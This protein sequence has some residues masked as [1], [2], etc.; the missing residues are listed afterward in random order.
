MP[1]VTP[2]SPACFLRV[3]ER[4]TNAPIAGARVEG[5]GSWKT[6]ADGQAE[7]AFS[8]ASPA[9]L[10]IRAEGFGSV[11]ARPL[12]GHATRSTAQ[13][14]Y[15]SKPST[16]RVRVVDLHGN[17]IPAV[18]VM[19][20]AGLDNLV[21]PAPSEV[22]AMWGEEIQWGGH[23]D[24]TGFCEFSDLPSEVRITARLE[25][26]ARLCHFDSVVLRPGEHVEREWRLGTGTTV[27]GLL[28]DQS[29][30]PVA[31]ELLFLQPGTE[32]GAEALPHAGFDNTLLVGTDESGRFT[33]PDLADG[34]WRLGKEATNLTAIHHS[35]KVGGPP[36]ILR[37]E[38]T[39]TDREVVVRFDREVYIEGQVLD[40]QGVGVGA[41]W[42]EARWIDRPELSTIVGF[43]DA[44]GS[45]SV[46]PVQR[47]QY[48]LVAGELGSGSAW[49]SHFAP[50]QPR[51]V[52]AGDQHVEVRLNPGE[53]LAGRVVDGKTGVTLTGETQFEVWSVREQV[54]WGR[55]D[56]ESFQL[57][58]LGP[59]EY[60]VVVRA[61]GGLIGVISA[62]EVRASGN[63]ADVRVPVWPGASLYVRYEG[64]GE[65]ATCSVEDESGS[66]ATWK[67]ERG[68]ASTRLVVPGRLRVLARTGGTAEPTG[69]WLDLEP[70]ES[71]QVVLRDTR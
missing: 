50:S 37:L 69:E 56:V 59:G 33:I 36:F 58:G 26:V 40:P 71:R 68:E 25:C 2:S 24:Q 32:S 51:T 1:S 34:T 48:V 3:L 64:P 16:L 30:Q 52:Q 66:V 6:D 67:L 54:A 13:T 38:A 31:G 44:G 7:I 10:T 61:Q 70:G 46:G 28:L 43:S 29:D 4:E 49:K 39:E 11:R 35:P 17:P 27:C 57:W 19:L 20:S 55:Q 45:F 53:S 18:A 5:G 41:C 8:P 14:V 21:H 42:V 9:V 22:T 65:R 47:G 23:T 63:P 62:A 60:R 12:L 15:L